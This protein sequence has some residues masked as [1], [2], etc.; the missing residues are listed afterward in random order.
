MCRSTLA[1]PSGCETYSK[2][3]LSSS[4]LRPFFSI[5]IARSDESQRRCFS[6]LCG[7]ECAMVVPFGFSIG[8]FFGAA[9]V[10]SQVLKALRK[11]GGAED[12]YWAV[13]L[14]VEL[15]GNNL[16]QVEVF[17]RERC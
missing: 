3:S 10:L 16:K 7:K 8:D 17:D 5:N 4:F 15:F 9:S 6:H 1:Q 14:E 2:F 11:H 13:C 12:N